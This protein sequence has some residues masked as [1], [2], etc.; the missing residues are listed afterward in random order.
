MMTLPNRT[1][2][3]ATLGPATDNDD[4]VAQLIKAGTNV[5]RINC[6]HADHNGIVDRIRLVRRVAKACDAP[7]GI[8]A[9]L[10]GPKMRVG[11]LKN[12]EP[13]WLQ[14]GSPLIIVSDKRVM[15]EDLKNGEPIRIASQYELLSSDVKAGER[16]L[17][18]DGNIEVVV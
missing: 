1:K 17:I 13:I 8:L 9:D 3:V 6:S 5:F 14:P 16:I 2:I 11:K 18:D 7:I 12:E 15:G 4:V 10:Q